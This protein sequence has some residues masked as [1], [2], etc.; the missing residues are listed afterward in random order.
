MC[1]RV[2]EFATPKHNDGG[3][4]IDY[5]H[6]NGGLQGLGTR[7]AGILRNEAPGTKKGAG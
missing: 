6:L 4:L 3:H 1:G 5:R 7:H 2:L